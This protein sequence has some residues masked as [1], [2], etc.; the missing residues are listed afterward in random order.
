MFLVWRGSQYAWAQSLVHLCNMNT[1]LHAHGLAYSGRAR[2]K[3]NKPT[4]STP[5]SGRCPYSPTS[6]WEHSLCAIS[7]SEPSAMA[8]NVKKHARGLLLTFSQILN[9]IKHSATGWIFF[10][11]CLL[12]PHNP[13]KCML[14]PTIS[15]S[16]NMRVYSSMESFYLKKCKKLASREERREK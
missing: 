16:V 13:T 14:P 15:D 1:P 5:R 8:D 4:V 7:S 6:L 3:Y 9:K 10:F 2:L 11:L 12:A